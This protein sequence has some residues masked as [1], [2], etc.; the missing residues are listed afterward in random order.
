MFAR[1]M[2]VGTR[3]GFAIVRPVSAFKAGRPTQPFRMT[4]SK[5][6]K[7]TVACAIFTCHAFSQGASTPLPIEDVLR[8]PNLAAYSPPA[9]SPDG[10]LLAYVVTDNARKRKSVGDEE[11]YRS[12]VAWYG[13]ASDIWITDLQSGKHRN[14]TAGGNNWSPSWSPDGRFLAFLADRSGKSE[15]GPARLWIWDR[16]AG[17]LRHVEAADVK[18][19]ILGGLH[20]S[21]D[22][23]SVLVALYPEE[24]GREGYA[25]R[26]KGRSAA[27][28]ADA[29]KEVTAKVFEFDPSAANAAPSTDQV[30]LDHWRR[31]VGFVDVAAGT[32]KRLIKGNRIGHYS[33]SPDRRKLAYTI[34]EGPEKPGTG[35][36]L[37]QLAVQDVGSGEPRIIAPNVRMTLYANSFGWSPGG[38]SIAY[39]TGGPSADDEV[40]VAEMAGGAA[41]RIAHN[42]S[43]DRLKFEV[44]PPVWDPGGRN[45]FF[46]RDHALWRAPV[47][48][49]SAALFAKSP[50]R[51]MELIAPRQHQ[52]FSPDG[53][54]TAVLMTL[55]P[56]TKRV[57]FAR[58][59]LKTG[60][61]AQI[62]EEDKRYGGYGTEPT[63]SPGSS[64]VAYVAED[65]LHPADIYIAGG[66]G[67]KSR[68]VTEVAPAFSNR[69]LGR[70]EVVE[71]RSIDGDTQRGALVYPAGY[72]KGRTYPLIVKVYGGSEISN[73][74]N[75]FGFASAA[76]E[77]LQ[78]YATRGYAILIA[79]SKVN[80]GTPMVDLMKTVMPGVGKVIDMGVAD[81]NRI[82]VTGHSYGGYSTLSLIVQSPLFKAAVMRAG[83]GDL[84]GGYGHLAPDGTNY[85]L[86]WSESG[87]GRMGGHPWEYRERY[88]ENSPVLYLDRVKTPLL[89][90]HGNE[91]DAVPAFL[92]DQIFTGL[93]RLGKPVSY[94]RYAGENHWEGGWS[95][96]NQVDSLERSI[97]WFDRYLNA[98]AVKPASTAR[99][100]R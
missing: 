82:G 28:S 76:Y 35:Q 27:A 9:F 19:G 11:Y 54:R 90:I 92:A 98:N 3:T 55:N 72:E 64:T 87:Q 68:R 14:I 37:Y 70:G 30:S 93:R 38:G 8:A 94:A 5:L 88:L 36:Y 61:A 6:L 24:L 40:Y 81:R 60:A 59:D 89:I 44:D 99:G 17:R 4:Y 39:R 42:P 49:S 13:V 51:Q 78:I 97:A 58:V 75:R 48:S 63:I 52:L 10:K 86:A 46:L 65:A 53:G 69:I 2:N 18:D 95:Y 73:D 83:M 77:N 50:G 12:G 67:F 62:S 71:W 66:D 31:D 34:L 84:V 26:M 74:L 22:G 45:I 16:T 80:V 21:A 15:L 43:T 56:G 32:V 57:G 41:R 91:D 1:I 47:D 79:D 33:L 23:G 7:F 20:W 100:G 29:T 25:A 85:G 96:P